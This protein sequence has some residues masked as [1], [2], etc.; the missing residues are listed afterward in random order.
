MGSDVGRGLNATGRRRRRR[1]PPP[2]R[3]RSN[4]TPP[5]LASRRTWRP[6]PRAR[7]R[8]GTDC[9]RAR[10][11]GLIAELLALDVPRGSLPAAFLAGGRPGAVEETGRVV[12][13]HAPRGSRLHAATHLRHA[14]HP[15]PCGVSSPLAVV[16]DALRD[17]AASGDA[18]LAA[19]SL[20]A[21]L[22]S[23][24]AGDRA[25]PGMLASEPG[26]GTPWRPGPSPPSRE[27][28]GNAAAA[29]APTPPPPPSRGASRRRRLR[30]R[31][32]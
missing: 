18:R 14:P 17:P 9:G 1:A 3:V 23:R 7:H 31:G 10:L 24:T 29:P 32:R 21:Q 16:I 26:G 27:S 20:C 12:R 25:F 8:G 2:R 11:L 28:P 5:P 4:S 22:A 19:L 15:D 13:R 30:R 6:R